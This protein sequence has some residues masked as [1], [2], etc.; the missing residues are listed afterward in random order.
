[1]S[2]IQRTS[3]ETMSDEELLSYV[4]DSYVIVGRGLTKKK[5]RELGLLPE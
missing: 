3:D 2:W 5:Q 1:M 4:R